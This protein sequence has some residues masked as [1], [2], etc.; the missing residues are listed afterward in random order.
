MPIKKGT[1]ELI[2]AKLKKDLIDVD[3]EL[4]RNKRIIKDLS[5]KNYHIK[6][7]RTKLHQ[8]IYQISQEVK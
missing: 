6:R 7:A 4:L 1:S 3:V 2:I 8:L 5:E